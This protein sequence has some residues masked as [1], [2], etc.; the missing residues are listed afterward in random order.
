MSCQAPPALDELTLAAGNQPTNEPAPR[1]VTH[2]AR[3]LCAVSVPF[4]S[5]LPS[6]PLFG[7]VRISACNSARELEL[8]GLKSYSLGTAVFREAL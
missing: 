4:A 7:S 6:T 8:Q 5:P 3:A 1:Y 2:C